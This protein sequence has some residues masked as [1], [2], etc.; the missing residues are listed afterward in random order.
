MPN[1]PENGTEPFVR[2]TSLFN[3]PRSIEG[4]PSLQFTAPYFP[5]TYLLTGSVPYTP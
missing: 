1:Y 4:N 3:F 2:L 5:T